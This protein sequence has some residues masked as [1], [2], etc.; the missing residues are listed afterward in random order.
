MLPCAAADV[1]DAQRRDA[2]RECKKSAVRQHV[3]LIIYGL[4]Q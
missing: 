3:A 1:R 4:A 2:M